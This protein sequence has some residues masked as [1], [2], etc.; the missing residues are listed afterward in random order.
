MP[1]LDDIMAMA[2][3]AQ[4]GLQKAQDNLDKVEVEGVSGGG[5]VK[6][7][8]TAKGR[9]LGVTIDEPDQGVADGAKAHRRRCQIG[10]LVGGSTSCLRQRRRHDEQRRAGRRGQGRRRAAGWS[11]L[12]GG[13][14]VEEFDQGERAESCHRASHRILPFD[15]PVLRHARRLDTGELR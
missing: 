10:R 1:N 7:K 6:V 15:S 3:N 11:R 14:G 5:L 12:A 2:Q 13:E 4:A 8:A 9:I